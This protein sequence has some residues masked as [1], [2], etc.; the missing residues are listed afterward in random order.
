MR[1][2]IIRADRGGV[3]GGGFSCRQT[4]MSKNVWYLSLSPE[5]E[6]MRSR[7]GP[8]RAARRR[9]LRVGWANDAAPV[10]VRGVV[11]G[12]ADEQDTKIAEPILLAPRSVSFRLTVMPLRSFSPPW[13]VP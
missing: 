5:C 3:I 9:A 7:R 4:G 1:E 2:R 13:T 12:R 10:S 11:Q 8:W 6:L